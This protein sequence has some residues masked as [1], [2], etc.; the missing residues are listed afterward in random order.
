MSGI[1]GDNTGDHSGQIATV[2]GITTSSSDPAI[3][4]DPSGGIGTVWANTTS[5]EM[6]ACTDA[7]AGANVWTNVGDGTGDIQINYGGEQ[8]GYCAGGIVAATA[9]NEIAKYSYTSDGDATD[10]GDI[11][12]AR[13][14]GAGVSSLT[15]GYHMGGAWPPF[16]PTNFTVE[17][18]KT[19]FASD[20]DAASVTGDLTGYRRLSAS[21]TN[22]VYGYCIADQEAPRITT[23]EKFLFSTEANAV[24]VG[25]LTGA[26]SSVGCS[27]S[28]HGYTAGGN[29]GAPASYA[30]TNTIQKWTFAS[31][32]SS[33]D[34]DDLTV[35]GNDATGASS[36]THGYVSGGTSRTTTIDKFSMVS[37]ASAT[38]VG[39]CPARTYGAGSSSTTFGY[40]ASGDDGGVVT[41]MFKYS[42]SSDGDSSSVGNLT[43]ATSYPWG[44]LQY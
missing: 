36:L 7:T 5:G 37:D 10:V 24:E 31:D 22:K 32:G 3:D 42:F 27:S 43:Y 40:N 1:I 29:I 19:Q 13:Y 15:Y 39:D 33:A 8:Y 2:Q 44:E 25:T 38:D 26:R 18:E 9:D 21:A 34:V 28:T 17:L 30:A 6:Y 20:G 11:V 35:A 23:Y 41:N 4:T 14:A 12:Q 16:S